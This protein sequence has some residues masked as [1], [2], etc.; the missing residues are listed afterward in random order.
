M[1]WQVCDYRF[2]CSAV[3]IVVMDI[4]SNLF[5]R[6]T[7]QSS[8][9]STEALLSLP[10]ALPLHYHHLSN[11]YIECFADGYLY[12]LMFTLLAQSY[13][14]ALSHYNISLSRPT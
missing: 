7:R 1:L 10:T 11:F 14:S 8:L 6:I 9:K 2:I 12:N 4:L 3:Y 5:Q 13:L